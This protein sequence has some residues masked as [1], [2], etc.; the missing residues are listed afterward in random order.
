MSPSENN[1]L[2]MKSNYQELT[3]NT[4]C[5]KDVVLSGGSTK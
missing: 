5:T 1:Y 3:Q 2:T 4:E